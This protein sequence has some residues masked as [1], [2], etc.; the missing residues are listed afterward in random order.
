MRNRDIQLCSGDVVDPR[1]RRDHRQR[2]V[3]R[4]QAEADVPKTHPGSPLLLGVLS[5]RLHTGIHGRVS[6]L[7][8]ALCLHQRLDMGGEYGHMACSENLGGGCKCECHVGR[9]LGPCTHLLSGQRRLQQG[10]THA[11]VWL[12]S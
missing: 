3:N 1:Q 4:A 11:W 5:L 7:M 9:V 8:I 10:T 2:D 6:Y 12:V